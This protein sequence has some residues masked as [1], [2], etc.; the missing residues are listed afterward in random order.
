MNWVY[1]LIFAVFVVAIL[2]AGMLGRDRLSADKAPPPC[3][4]AALRTSRRY[5]AASQQST[6]RVMAHKTEKP[7]AAVG[8]RWSTLW[9]TLIIALIVYVL[10]LVALA[11]DELVLGTYWISRTA[12]AGSREVFFN[13]YPFLRFLQ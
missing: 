7:D 4:K 3:K 1:V 2:L 11:I 6:L 12:P 5:S 10:P 9:T 13:V 8:D